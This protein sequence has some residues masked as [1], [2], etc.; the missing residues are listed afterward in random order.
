[1]NKAWTHELV[2]N[3]GV[4]IREVPL[5]G[6]LHDGAVEPGDAVGTRDFIIVRLPDGMSARLGFSDSARSVLARGDGVEVVPNERV[7]LNNFL[8]RLLRHD[9]DV[10]NGHDMM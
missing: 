9:P 5:S 4:F 1:M 7:V 2:L 10:I 3:A 6:P 8:T